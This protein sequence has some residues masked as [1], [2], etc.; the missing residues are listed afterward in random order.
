MEIKN[1]TV[2]S[3]ANFTLFKGLSQKDLTVDN[4][5]QPNRLNVRPTWS[6]GLDNEGKIQRF[7]FL[8]GDNECPD[9]IAEWESFRKMCD[10]GV[11]G[12]KGSYTNKQATPSVDL[13]ALK[14]L[15][16]E[17]KALLKRLEALEG[18]EKGKQNI[19]ASKIE[20]A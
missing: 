15:E 3:Q 20:E 9:Y 17:N 12:I 7:D 16:E 6:H 8:A 14:K 1:I 10:N 18:K 2:V 19:S 13:T 5:A 11:L 4:K